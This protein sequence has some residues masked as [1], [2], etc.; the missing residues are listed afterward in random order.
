[1][2]LLS[3]QAGIVKIVATATVP[4]SILINPFITVYYDV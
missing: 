1:M 2:V 3:L 4:V